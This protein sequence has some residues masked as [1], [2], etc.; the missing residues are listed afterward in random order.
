[1]SN[2]ISDLKGPTPMSASAILPRRATWEFQHPL[3]VTDRSVPQDERLII[4][5]DPAAITGSVS[6]TGAL[7]ASKVVTPI[8]DTAVDLK[9]QRQGLDFLTLDISKA[10]MSHPI[11][12]TLARN[13]TTVFDADSSFTRIYSPAGN[14]MLKGSPTQTKLTLADQSLLLAVTASL[15]ASKSIVTD[16]TYT[17]PLNFSDKGDNLST[18]GTTP[19]RFTNEISIASNGIWTVGLQAAGYDTAA[20]KGYMW[21]ATAY[22]TR[23]AG[24]ITQIDQIDATSD[25]TA[26]A[27]VFDQI[28]LASDALAMR[29][30]TTTNDS[31][32]VDFTGSVGS[33]I[34][35]YYKAWA[36]LEYPL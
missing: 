7:T 10:Y 9:I 21:E 3:T 29:A 24:V 18:T 4:G 12:M 31:I 16:G 17:N 33:A 34:T 25:S 30:N 20:G 32:A 22:V 2:W 1:M 13:T 26:A 27:P 8:L 11:E 6:L 23:V 19:A 36:R 35:S 15:S 5:W 14:Q 28:G